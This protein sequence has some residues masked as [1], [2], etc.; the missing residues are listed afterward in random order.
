MSDGLAD[1]KKIA[2]VIGTRPEIIKMAPV[3]RE[4]QVRGVDFFI[5]HSN[6]H[7][8][9]EMDAIF[10]DQLEL[11]APD[12]NLG[13]GSGLHANQTGNILIKIEPILERQKPDLVMVQGDTNTVMAAALAASKLGIKVGHVEAGLRSYDRTMPE[14]TNRVLTDHISDFL[15]SV[16]PNQS[17]IL[18][19]EGISE[20]QIFEVGNTISDALFQHLPMAE[21]K[22]FV[23]TDLNLEPRSYILLTAH[24]ASNVDVEGHLRE[25]ID[26]VTIVADRYQKQVVWPIHPRTRKKLDEYGLDLGPGVTLLDPLGYFDFIHLQANASLIMTDSGGIQEE[27]CM[28]RVPCVTLRQNTERPE[29]VEVGANVLVGRDQVLAIEAIDRWLEADSYD[30]ANPFGDGTVAA[31]ILDVVLG[32]RETNQTTVDL[33]D[34]KPTVAVIGQGYMGLPIAALIANA[35]HRVTGVDINPSVVDQVNEGRCPFDEVGLPELISKVVNAGALT[36]STKVPSSDIYLVAVP[37][38]HKD[39]RC[40]LTYVEAAIDSIVEVAVNGQLVIIE[41]T[42]SPQTSQKMQQRLVEGGLEIDVVHCPERAIPGNTLHELVNNDRIIGSSSEQSATVAESLYRS[43]VKGDIF[44]TD[45]TTAE[46]VKLIENTSRDVQIAFANEL[47]EITSELG[48]NVLE[49]IRLA[50]RH[51]R[52]NILNPGPGVGGHCIPIDPW[53][54]V[55]NTT[56]GDLVRLCRG[57]NDLQPTR[58]VERLDPIFKKLGAKKLV[59]LGVAYK[60][61]VDDTRETPAEPIYRLLTNNGYEVRYYDP[62]IESWVCPNLATIQQVDDWADAIILLTNHKSFINIKLSTPAYQ[63]LGTSVNEQWG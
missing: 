41:S 47:A 58:V 45:T 31:T 34:N 35:G 27:A 49:A 43:F 46:C 25:L 20:G 28:L 22:S 40:D 26:L 48:V 21:E 4:C 55:A 15:F 6:Q 52:V 33:D 14:E 29:T 32:T 59:L 9:A 12:Y 56:A 17:R 63:F 54:L 19:D 36:A 13:V 11:P 30:W 23:L 3:I 53:F 57:I 62:Y 51:P 1:I 10:F 24:R 18:R 37:T 2:I 60:P 42:I 16:G 7:Y 44:H 38:P 61:D 5:V 50:N 8:S 39:Q